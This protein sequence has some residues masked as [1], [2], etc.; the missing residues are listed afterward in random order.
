LGTVGNAWHF[1]AEDMESTSSTHRSVSARLT[2]DVVKPLRFFADGQVKTRKAA[3]VAV[4]KRSR[5]LAEWRT[6]EAKAKVRESKQKKLSTKCVF[7]ASLPR[8]LP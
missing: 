5:S 8:Y 4:D 6:A 3:E 7:L 1:I 2:E